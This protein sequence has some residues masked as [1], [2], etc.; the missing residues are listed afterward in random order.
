MPRSRT[1]LLLLAA[2]ALIVGS[3]GSALHVHDDT[4]QSCRLCQSVVE[5]DLPDACAAFLGDPAVERSARVE[6]YPC[7]A[8]RV[9]A[10]PVLLR[11]PPAVPPAV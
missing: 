6:D 4:G 2:I 5:S 10:T 7:V 11:A 9:V 3:M 8:E 1:S